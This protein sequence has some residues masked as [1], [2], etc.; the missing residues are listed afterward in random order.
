MAKGPVRDVM[1]ENDDDHR[2]DGLPEIIGTVIGAA[3][4]LAVFA[5]LGFAVLVGLASHL[6]LA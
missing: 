1:A 5:M 6:R 2:P 4:I 3:I